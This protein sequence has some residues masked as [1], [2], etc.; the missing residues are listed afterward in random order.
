MYN[1]VGAT[2]ESGLERGIYAVR[3]SV[4]R[5]DATLPSIDDDLG[6]ESSDRSVLGETRFSRV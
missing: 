3:Y 6:H 2:C 4:E 5:R 1:K